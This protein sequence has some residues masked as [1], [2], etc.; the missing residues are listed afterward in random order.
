[1]PN[2]IVLV[3]SAKC[4]CLVYVQWTSQSDSWWGV[5]C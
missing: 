4:V 2:D 5:K 3:I 1:M